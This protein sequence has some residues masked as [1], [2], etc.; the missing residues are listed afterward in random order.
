MVDRKL[1]YDL[2][3]IGVE[4]KQFTLSAT[5]QVLVLIEF[6]E[7]A[8]SGARSEFD[9]MVAFGGMIAFRVIAN[10]GALQF[11]VEV[12]FFASLAPV[13]R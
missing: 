1:V 7:A 11:A 8:Q 5:E 4:Q 6:A 9:E 12:A 10:G 13:D 3:L 2:Q